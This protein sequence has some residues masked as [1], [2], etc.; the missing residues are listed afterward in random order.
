MNPQRLLC[1]TYETPKTTRVSHLS[2]EGKRATSHYDLPGRPLHVRYDLNTERSKRAVIA[3][4]RTRLRSASR[5]FVRACRPDIATVSGP[6]R[7][8]WVARWKGWLSSQE[9]KE[10]NQMLW[11]LV[12]LLRPDP[13]GRSATIT[14]HEITFALAPIVPQP[15][16]VEAVS[17]RKTAERRR[18]SK[19]PFV[20]TSARN[21]RREIVSG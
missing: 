18:G 8:L 14:C 6:R 11:G 3:L 5:G 20:K 12:N 7:N 9:L 19:P 15:A 4:A 2:G 21:P 16:A 10:A 13:G 1:A 17:K